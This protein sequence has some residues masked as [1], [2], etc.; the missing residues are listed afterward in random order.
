MG[1]LKSH[2]DN[3]LI[4]MANIDNYREDFSTEG[5][6][7]MIEPTTDIASEDPSENGAVS[8]MV[9]FTMEAVDLFKKLAYELESHVAFREI[10]EDIEPLPIPNLCRVFEQKLAMYIVSRI[11]VDR[12][13]VGLYT[14]YPSD[15][16]EGINT[17]LINTL[18]KGYSTFV[19]EEMLDGYP[20]TLLTNISGADRFHVHI[21]G[22]S[23]RR[24][25]EIRQSYPDWL[26]PEIHNLIVEIVSLTGQ[27]DSLLTQIEL[28]ALYR[29]LRAGKS[30][31]VHM[32][33][34]AIF[35][36]KEYET[37]SKSRSTT[38]DELFSVCKSSWLHLVLFASIQ[39]GYITKTIEDRFI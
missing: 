31:Y 11:L 32:L 3:K 23:M 29:Y 8:F 37:R 36:L 28:K 5:L 21:I 12:S 16:V 15:I 26:P 38:E 27:S 2:F 19:E 6:I 25:I 9:S 24:L 18:E 20:I 35:E 7:P 33:L 34:N 39:N 17:L 22:E 30:M 14:A 13:Y 10:V 4:E 1:N